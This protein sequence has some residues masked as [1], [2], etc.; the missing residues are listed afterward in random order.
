MSSPNNPA[1][2]DKTPFTPLTTPTQPDS[3]LSPASS[4]ALETGSETDI[5]TVPVAQLRDVTKV[6]GE[7]GTRVEALRS[8]SVDINAREFTVIMGPSGSGKSTLLHV[9]AGLDAVTSGSIT[10]NR[11][12][13]TKL[14]DKPLTLWR[15]DNVGFVFQSFNLVPTLS[16]GANIELPLRLANKPID[17]HWFDQIVTGLDL[18]TRLNHKPYELSGGQM[19][20]VAVARALLSRPALLV[21]DE[22]TGNLDTAS[23]AE[24]LNLLRAAVD[25]FG[26][27]VV[28]VTH[29]QHAATTGDRVLIVRDGMIVHDLYHPEPADIAKVA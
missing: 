21:A 1:M 24:V 10:V 20:R 3:T 23:S 25:N 29:D 8:V 16:A 17:R 18:T 2:P 6:Y 15:R 27:T 11:M 12:D 7:K 9:L 14:K 19:Q 22:P 28:M 26:Q 5:P 13:I 4:T